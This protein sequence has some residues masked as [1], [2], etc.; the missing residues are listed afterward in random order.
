MQNFQPDPN[1]LLIVSDSDGCNKRIYRCTNDSSPNYGRVS[2]VDF[3]HCERA[4][5]TTRLRGLISPRRL[6][7]AS[8]RLRPQ[9]ADGRRPFGRPTNHNPRRQQEA[10]TMAFKFRFQR[11]NKTCRL[12]SLFLRGLGVGGLGVG[13]ST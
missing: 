1:I 10:A 11:D 9:R 8:A 13:E 2:L 12:A 3:Q 5:A 4:G 6:L 7:A